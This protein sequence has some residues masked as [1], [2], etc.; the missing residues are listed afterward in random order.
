MLQASF[1]VADPNVSPRRAAAVRDEV[2]EDEWGS[3][4]RPDPLGI[5][6]AGRH[7]VCMLHKPHQ[8]IDT[9]QVVADTLHA[10]MLSVDTGGEQSSKQACSSLQRVTRPQQSWCT[11]VCK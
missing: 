4:H 5:V 6:K 2:T 7:G 3:A 8:N 10:D 9:L 1:D 11:R